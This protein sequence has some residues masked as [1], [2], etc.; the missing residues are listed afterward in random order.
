MVVALR[1]LRSSTGV[2][3]VVEC[4][5]AHTKMAVNE[6]LATSSLARFYK[7][8]VIKI[9]QY[10]DLRVGVRGV[11]SLHCNPFS[12]ISFILRLNLQ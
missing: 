4:H 10:F 12:A 3:G 5:L 7:D 6:Q 1:A 2:E 8:R 11:G 9:N